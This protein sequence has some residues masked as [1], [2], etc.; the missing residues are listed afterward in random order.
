M[1]SIEERLDRI[2]KLLNRVFER[3]REIEEAIR[4]AGLSGDVARVAYELTLLY[5]TPVTL[6]LESAKRFASIMSKFR[7]DPISLEV[8]KALSLC[9]EMSVSDVTR[10]VKRSRGSASRRIVRERLKSLEELGIVVNVGSRARP[11]FT[12]KKCLEKT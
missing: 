12:L 2:E 9:R 4:S 7:L 6:A 11:R 1:S 5:S 8:V 10:A 3:L